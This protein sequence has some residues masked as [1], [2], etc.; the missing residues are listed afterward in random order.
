MLVQICTVI[1]DGEVR[2]I[3][4]RELVPVDVVMLEKGDRIPAVLRLLYARKLY[5]H[6]NRT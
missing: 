6:G 4:T 5:A 1:R 2:D 3:P